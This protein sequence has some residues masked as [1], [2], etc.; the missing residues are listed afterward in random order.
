MKNNV[1]VIGAG[2]A[3][4]EAAWQLAQ[5]GVK[6]RLFEQKPDKKSPAHCGKGFAEL[7]CSNSLR[8]DGI[9]SAVGLLKQEMR[10]LDS[11]VMRA[12]DTARVPAGRRIGGGSGSVFVLYHGNADGA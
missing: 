2:L 1:A 12:A 8:A 11:L 4:S 5:R 10:K 3:G 9:E 7:V 6:V